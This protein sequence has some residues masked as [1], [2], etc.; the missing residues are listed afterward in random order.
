MAKTAA[1][2]P[3]AEETKAPAQ[4]LV[5]LSV[6][7]NAETA[8]ALKQIAD[9][10]GLSYT[11]AVRRAISITKFIEDELEE[12]R[13]IQTVDADRKDVRELILM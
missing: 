7:M 3:K 1:S 9:E 5:R 6:N 13:R 12:G 11:E 2:A 4:K 8:E 10:R